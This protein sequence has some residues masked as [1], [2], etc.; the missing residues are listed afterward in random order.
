M[1]GEVVWSVKENASL[2][3][4][5]HLDDKSNPQQWDTNAETF[6][7]IHYELQTD[8]FTLVEDVMKKLKV[9]DNDI[10]RIMLLKRVQAAIGQQVELFGQDYFVHMKSKHYPEAPSN[11]PTQKISLAELDAKK[12]L[13]TSQ[14]LV[15]MNVTYEEACALSYFREGEIMKGLREVATVE[16]YRPVLVNEVKAIIASEAL[17]YSTDQTAMLRKQPNEPITFVDLNALYN[18]MAQKM[19]S[20]VKIMDFIK[21]AVPTGKRQRDTYSYE[22]REAIV[23]SIM[24]KSLCTFNSKLDAYKV[25]LSS[26]LLNNGTSGEFELDLLSETND[27]YP[28]SQKRR[29]MPRSRGSKND[30]AIYKDKKSGRCKMINLYDLVKYDPADGGSEEGEGEEGESADCSIDISDNQKPFLLLSKSG[31]TGSRKR[32]G[33]PMKKYHGPVTKMSFV[34]ENATESTSGLSHVEELS[35]VEREDEREEE[36]EVNNENEH[37]DGEITAPVEGVVEIVTEPNAMELALSVISDEI[38]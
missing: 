6:L 37:V 30:V 12:T 7:G 32:K 34:T 25:Q 28:H 2:Y 21:Q 1:E 23:A 33:I 15:A 36:R 38:N 26:L 20:Y 18:E 4:A 13:A 3:E 22:R 35:I 11:E 14:T 10:P 5:L 27:T 16:D 19:P 29:F 17:M 8:S 31:R 9:T 24:A